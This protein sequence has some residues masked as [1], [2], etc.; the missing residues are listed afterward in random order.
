L[1]LHNPLPSSPPPPL[2]APELSAQF[3]HK[4][5]LAAR[6]A[7]AQATLE[8]L[9]GDAKLFSK[10]KGKQTE[11]GQGSESAGRAAVFWWREQQR[12]SPPATPGY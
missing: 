6:E 3:N 8:M 2:P 9:K 5:P 4:P 10:G 7:P 11:A 1:R 12:I